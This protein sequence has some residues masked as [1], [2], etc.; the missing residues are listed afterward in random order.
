MGTAF[1]F[2]IQQRK[3]KDRFAFFTETEKMVTQG[4]TVTLRLR[5]S[6]VYGTAFS[7]CSN[8]SIYIDGVKQEGLLTDSERRLHFLLWRQEMFPICYGWKSWWKQKMVRWQP[9]SQRLMP[10]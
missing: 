10:M 9:Q 8:A 4:E 1:I 3:G 5:Q 7:D 6:N 2:Y